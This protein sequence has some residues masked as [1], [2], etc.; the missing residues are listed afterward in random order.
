MNKLIP[1]VAIVLLGLALPL[2]SCEG[3]HVVVETDWTTLETVELQD[4]YNKFMDGEWEYVYEDSIHFIEM[5][6][7]FST[8]DSTMTGYY[9]DVLRT[10]VSPDGI[11]EHDEWQLLWQG[12]FTAKWVL[13]HSVDL[14]QAYIYL[15]NLKYE[16]VHGAL[17][18]YDV[19]AG[20][21]L[22]YGATKSTLTLTTP[23]TFRRVDMHRRTAPR[24]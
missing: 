2:A 18:A 20:R 12:S 16:N 11:P 13:L 19:M 7:T 3:D 21:L 17:S 9:N 6:Y 14:N 5:F 10:K 24:Q 15:D 1:I 4:T 22:F 8:K 23:L